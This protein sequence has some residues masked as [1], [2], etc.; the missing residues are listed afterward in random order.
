[1][2]DTVKLE[3]LL[4]LQRQGARTVLLDV[5]SELEY[6]AGHLEGAVN[7]PLDQIRARIDEIVPSART[8]LVVYC[9]SG[10]RAKQAQALLTSLSYLRT[11]RLEGGYGDATDSSDTH[12]L[13]TSHSPRYSRQRALVGDLGQAQIEAAHILVVGA[14]G[15]GSPV[16]LYLA[17]AGIG[18]LTIADGDEVE[19]SNLHRQVIH[20]TGR[21]GQAKTESARTAIKDLNPGV[22]VR[23]LQRLTAESIEAALM[24]CSVIV[25]GSDNLETRYLVGDAARKAR[26]PVIQGAVHKTEGQLA[27]YGRLGAQCYCYRCVFPVPDTSVQAC[28]T[29][30]VMGPLCGALGSLMAFEVLRIV[31]GEVPASY[32]A[33]VSLDGQTLATHRIAV[34]QPCAQCSAEPSQVP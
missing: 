16:C 15:L 6:L 31:R 22:K 11:Q 1:M 33:L 25:D 24:E 20:T 18:T 21:V 19:L 12:A 10:A 17:A 32:G 4:W 30:G 8:P 26:K 23:A 2:S 14:G 34:S 5:R 27:S 3:T 28:S 9:A 13:E 7:L 29:L